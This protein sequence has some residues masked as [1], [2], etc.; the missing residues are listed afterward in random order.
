MENSIDG[1][2]LLNYFL[3]PKKAVTNRQYYK[4]KK[5]KIIAK[6]YYIKGGRG[7]RMPRIHDNVFFLKDSYWVLGTILSHDNWK[8]LSVKQCDYYRNWEKFYNYLNTKE[9]DEFY[10]YEDT[11]THQIPLKTL[12][13]TLEYEFNLLLEWYFNNIYINT[14]ENSVELIRLQNWPLYADMPM[15]CLIYNSYNEYYEWKKCYYIK[16]DGRKKPATI[17]QEGKMGNYTMVIETDLAYDKIEGMHIDTISDFF[18]KIKNNHVSPYV[19]TYDDTYSSLTILKLIEIDEHTSEATVE[20][21]TGAGGG[22]NQ[23][24]IPLNELVPIKLHKK[25]KIKEKM[26]LTTQLDQLNAKYVDDMR[27]AEAAL[28]RAQRSGRHREL[29]YTRDEIKDIN[30]NTAYHTSDITEKIT[31]LN[32]TDIKH[33]MEF[34]VIDED[35]RS[36]M[37]KQKGPDESI[38]MSA[39][40]TVNEKNCMSVSDET[41]NYFKTNYLE[42]YKPGSIEFKKLVLMR[43]SSQSLLDDERLERDQTNKR[44]KIETLAAMRAE[45]NQKQEKDAKEKEVI[46]STVPLQD[47]QKLLGTQSNLRKIINSVLSKKSAVKHI[48]FKKDETITIDYISTIKFRDDDTMYVL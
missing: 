6:S 40:H 37:P 2:N 36:S 11:D 48:Q 46:D 33:N 20:M 24:Q 47:L 15:Y 7:S 29:E 19:G 17:N 22:D 31:N 1:E 30:D 23:F 39:D 9:Y 21:I 28:N 35:K 18:L 13:G 10:P 45:V 5:W 44:H 25:D 43:A 42:K 26:N 16:T 14:S 8:G 3:K 41:F 34:M 32:S 4:A 27:R 12:V 38:F